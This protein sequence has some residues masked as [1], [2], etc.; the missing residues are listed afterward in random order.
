MKR[1]DQVENL[2]WPQRVANSRVT[3]RKSI[4]PRSSPL[5]VTYDEMVEGSTNEESSTRSK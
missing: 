3:A 1:N 5:N 2:R 4:S